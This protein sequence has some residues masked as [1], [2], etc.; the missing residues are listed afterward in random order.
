VGIVAMGT[1]EVSPLSGTTKISGPLPMD[2]RFPGSVN[3]PMTFTTE[4]VAFCEVDEL[5][6]E[7]PQFVAIP[8][9]VAIK[10]PSHRLCM[11]E[12]DIGMFILQVSVLPVHLQGGMAIAA[13]EHA[14]CHRRRGDRKLLACTPYKGDK[15]NP[16]QK[17]NRNSQY[18]FIHSVTNGGKSGDPDLLTYHP[19][20]KTRI[21]CNIFS[22]KKQILCRFLVRLTKDG[23]RPKVFPC[24][25]YEFTDDD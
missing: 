23:N 24:K 11:M 9:I 7:K 22:Y 17:R 19:F 14:L 2:P 4:F 21:F 13:G 5:P 18:L 15:A 12:L 6:V 1:E 20:K 3:V 10:A 16:R 8:C 25:A